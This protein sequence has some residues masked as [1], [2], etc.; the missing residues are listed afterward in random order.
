VVA[1]V[2]AAAEAEHEADDE[3]DQFHGS[4]QFEITGI[5]P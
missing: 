2:D 5:L 3:G 1:P 4:L